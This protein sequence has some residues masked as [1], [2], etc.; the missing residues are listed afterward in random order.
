M[1][2]Q[3]NNSSESKSATTTTYSQKSTSNPAPTGIGA[4]VCQYSL[5]DAAVRNATETV[6]VKPFEIRLTKNAVKLPLVPGSISF[7][8]SGNRYVDYLG[9]IFRNPD[10][11]TG[12]G[13]LVGLVDYLTG[14][15]TLHVHD[16]GDNTLTVHSLAGRLGSQ[17]LTEVEFRTPGAPLRPGS[18][19]VAG[20][21]M[22]GKRISATAGFD[23]KI[24][25]EFVEGEIDHTTG[26]VTLGFGEAI[27]DSAA[28][29]GED[30]YNPDLVR[31]G[32]VWKPEPVYAD[33]LTYACVVYTY[34]P[35]KASLLGLNP[36]RLP[37]DGRVPIVK[38]GDVVVIHNTSK[39]QIAGAPTAGQV[40]TLPR[41]ADNVEIYDSSD[42]PLRVPTSMYAH[43]R[44]SDTITVDAANNDFSGYTM[45]LVANHRIEDMALVS[46]TRINGGITLTRGLTNSYPKEGTLVSSALLF[47]DMQAR[48][49]GLFDQKTWKNTFSDSVDGD[50]AAAT[51]NEIDYPVRVLNS[52]AVTE[53]WALV[54]TS[55]EGYNIVAEKRGVIMTNCN[56][57]EDVSPINT[58]TGKPYF[59]IYAAGFGSGWTSGNAVR[60]NTEGAAADVWAVRTTL[61]GPETEAY[62]W[63]TIQPRGDAR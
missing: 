54:F 41:A 3:F 48:Y 42:P 51:Y 19:T 1:R 32:K 26:I 21:T 61:Q 37:S 63:F 57:N 50:I 56:I 59:T 12:I 35:L 10:P 11:A 22:H 24:S 4:C 2:Y 36:V 52:G 55:Q 5:S 31:E 46:E 8:W 17:Y 33:S 20:V 44:G 30:W 39:M 6:A 23:G 47:G 15:V 27:P 53:R 45:P 43:E 13:T 9:G 25:G 58:A 16:G 60:F 40:I 7:T 38:P 62:D 34:I 14:V 29:A 49:Y 28:Y 18:F